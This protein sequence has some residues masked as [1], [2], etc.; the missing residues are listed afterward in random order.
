MRA[1]RNGA[2][3]LTNRPA[4]ASSMVRAG[5]G[6]GIVA[7]IFGELRKSY[8][9][10]AL[11]VLHRDDDVIAAV[12]PAGLIVHPLGVLTKGAFTDL[13]KRRVG[14]PVHVT[15]RLDRLTSGVLIGTFSPQIASRVEDS[16]IA[17]KVRKR[18]LALVVGQVPW[19]SQHVTNMLGRDLESSIRLKRA[20]VKSD[21]KRAETEFI[22]R[23]RFGSHTLVE[24]RPRTGRTHQI[25][26]HLDE[27]GFPIVRDK[28]YGPDFDEEYFETGVGNLTP[29]LEDWHG[30]HAWNIALP[31]PVTGEPLEVN[32]PLDGP[33]ASRL[34][35]LRSS[36]RCRNASGEHEMGDPTE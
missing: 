8:D 32:A 11:T 10:R 35:E 33:M 34:E 30:L 14:A 31:H 16:F 4:K 36:E 24:A 29:Y 6:C 13:L 15:H 3:R 22:V 5:D 19:E 2:V 20:V 18:Y 28:L 27:M 26:V 1:V 9:Y 12:K 17:G 23:E 21:G 25:R 7:D